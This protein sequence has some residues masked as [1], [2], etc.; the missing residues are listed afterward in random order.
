MNRLYFKK[1]PEKDGVYITGNHNQ[2]H[3]RLEVE[4]V[5]VQGTDVLVD[6]DSEPFTFTD[7]DFWSDLQ[8]ETK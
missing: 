5:I 1:Y 2:L 7:F 8:E 6:G 4:F 3:N